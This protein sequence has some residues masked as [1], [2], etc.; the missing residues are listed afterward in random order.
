MNPPTL[1]ASWIWKVKAPQKLLIFVWL[2]SHNSIPV[3]KVLGTRGFTIDQSCPLCNNHV[4]TIDHLLREC[5]A[6]VSFWNQLGVP[7]KA[8][9]SFGLPLSDWLHFNSTCGF[10]SRHLHIPSK[11]LI[12]FGLWTLWLNRNSVAFQGK[13]P[14]PSI[15][16]ICIEKSAEFHFL[17]QG[18][19][20]QN[21]KIQH[22]IFWTKP[23]LGWFK[24]NTDASVLLSSNYASGG[25]LIRDSYGSWIRG[26]S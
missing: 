22:P 6:S 1:A 20:A 10:T 9:Q 25:G 23:D 8:I 5:Q 17:I 26:F 16:K 13:Q 12:I 14:N 11:T 21:K 2:C 7:S 15:A 4:E 18:V 19:E 24:L 3:R